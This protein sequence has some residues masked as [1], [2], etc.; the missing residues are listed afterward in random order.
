MGIIQQ[1][2]YALWH[3]DMV[4]LTNPSVQTALYI[5]L[6]T[7]I[8]LENGLLP[9]AFLPGDSLLVLVGV[10][11]AQNA[12][13]FSFVVLLLSVAAGLGSWLGF[14]QGK[15]LG[16]SQIVTNWLNHLPAQ[17]H[18]RAHQLF[19]KHG[20][21]AL[22]I[23][24]FI[25]FVRTLLPTMAGLSKLDTTRFQVFNFVSGFLWVIILTT[26]GYFLGNTP[27]FHKYEDQVMLVLVLLPA[28]LLVI[29]LVGS[30]LVIWKKKANS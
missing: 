10:L 27:L 23:G 21:A 2:V 4:L 15:W 20:L 7:I 8:F 30:L 14:V 22:L 28:A 18:T 16:N 12:L 19:Y 3:Q 5:M 17:Y 29:G 24:R 26:L 1:L 13:H 6:F 25:A 9:A 11:A